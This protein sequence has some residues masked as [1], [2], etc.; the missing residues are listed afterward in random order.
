MSKI[1]HVHGN[2]DSDD[3]ELVPFHGKR[4][5]YV[6]I[7][8][9]SKQLK[10]LNHVTLSFENVSSVQFCVDS[11]IGLPLSSTA[12]RV[13]VKLMEYNRTSV[14]E[15]SAPTY[16]SPDSDFN[17]PLFDLHMGWRGELFYYCLIILFILVLLLVNNY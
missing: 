5:S 11:A 8:V 15:G 6:S 13:S 17:A 3:D 14:G 10:K 7:P 12:T 1:H 16:S 4:T 9:Q 2:D